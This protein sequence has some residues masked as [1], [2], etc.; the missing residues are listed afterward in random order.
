MTKRIADP[1][2]VLRG[3]QSDVQ[4]LD[5]DPTE[6][7]VASGYVEKCIYRWMGKMGCM[8]LH[9]VFVCFVARAIS[10]LSALLLYRYFIFRITRTGNF[11][12]LDVEMHKERLQFGV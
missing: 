11:T 9:Q 5:F 12:N 10:C 4:C 1:F 2:S 8:H 3:H 7:Y 6:N